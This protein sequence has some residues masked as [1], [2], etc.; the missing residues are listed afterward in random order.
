[1]SDLVS[2]D[3]VIALAERDPTTLWTIAHT[4]E[5]QDD[6]QFADRV[7]QLSM[8]ALRKRGLISWLPYALSVDAELQWRM[9]A[10]ARARASAAECVEIA[11]TARQLGLIGF[12]LA[13]AGLIAG[14]TGAKEER[15]EHLRR[16]LQVAADTGF[17]PVELYAR[18]SYG[19]CELANGRPREAAAH[20]D[21][22][23]EIAV[24]VSMG[25]PS[26][27]QYHADHVEAL[28]R[29]GR[30]AD[31]DRACN[32]LR[33][34]AEQSGSRWATAAEL[35]CRAHLYP[36]DRN[37]EMWLTESID[38]FTTDVP[39]PYERHRSEL[40]LGA[41]QRRSRRLAEARHT[42][43]AAEAGFNKLGA[44]DWAERCATELRAAGAKDGGS[45]RTRP[46]ALSRLTTQQLQV[47]LTVA[48]GATN[49]EAAAAL[50]LSPKTVDYHLRRAYTSLGVH[51]RVEL[52]RLVATAP[53]EDRPAATQ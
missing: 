33:D 47:V 23:H 51:T 7:S 38:R 49:R 4:A 28:A 24:A 53:A 6:L 40:E 46:G 26:V 48:A 45:N 35:R 8:T 9:G 15:E 11:N 29:A 17:R 52:A 19:A 10:W 18:Q 36:D 20:L 32:A 2:W 22:A 34:A 31:A 39:Q 43:A 21:R 42:L 41:L 16:A 27:V 30:F 37:S 44:V 25:H 5:W 3:T 50:F 14:L 12:S 13:I 1:M